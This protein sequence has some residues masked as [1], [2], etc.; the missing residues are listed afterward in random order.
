MQIVNSGGCAACY[1]FTN[2]RLVDFGAAFDGP[3]LETGMQIDDLILCEDCVRSA[4]QALELDTN[5]DAVDRALREAEEARAKSDEW[6]A[7]ARKLEN[8][9]TLRPVE[10]LPVVKKTGKK[11]AA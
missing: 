2:K 6:Q 1:S 5:K 10:D 4:A 11:A 9:R 3:V 8:V 7:Y